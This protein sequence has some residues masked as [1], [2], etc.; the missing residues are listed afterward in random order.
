MSYAAVGQMALSTQQPALTSGANIDGSM[1]KA[2]YTS[3]PASTELPK[4]ATAEE[5]QMAKTHCVGQSVKG[6]GAVYPSGTK[7]AGM[8]PCDVA[9][10][11]VC[12]T[13]KALTFSQPS[14][15]SMKDSVTYSA[16]PAT[17]TAPSAPSMKDAS[18][19]APPPAP[20]APPPEAPTY[21]GP[22]Y[23]PTSPVYSAP[24]YTPPTT[25]VYAA[26]APPPN[27]KQKR[28]QLAVAGILA[29]LVVGGVGYAVYR[30][31]KKK[32]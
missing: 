32:G 31:S 28:R 18:T 22:A 8:D 5:L 9:K 14:A 30:S 24:A 4:C 23:A 13:A 27:E 12:L 21:T 6:L 20:S 2:A 3:Y 25:P 26:P 15:P 17:Y 29:V 1:L 7:F 10:L 11:P 16:P 19:Y